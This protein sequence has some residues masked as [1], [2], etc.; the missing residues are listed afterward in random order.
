VS[1][2][3]WRYTAA[4]ALS[5]LSMSSAL[6]LPGGLPPA[7]RRSRLYPAALHLLVLPFLAWAA[8]FFVEDRVIFAVEVAYILSM[9][10]WPASILLGAAADVQTHRLRQRAATLERAAQAEVGPLPR[11]GLFCLDYRAAWLCFFVPIPFGIPF[12]FIGLFMGQVGPTWLAV[13]WAHTGW[14]LAWAY[15]LWLAWRADSDLPAVTGR[16]PVRTVV[17]GVV[18]A[19]V[20]IAFKS[21]WFWRF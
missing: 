15:G 14:A 10:C 16:F 9:C 11:A 8:V 13:G 7:L 5:P 17:L 4:S 12:K 18:M 21:S 6:A 3:R 1:S 19:V 20:A 2:R